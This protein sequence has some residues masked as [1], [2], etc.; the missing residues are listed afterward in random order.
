MT[1]ANLKITFL[2]FGERIYDV[3]K[4]NN[5]EFNVNEIKIET[6]IE[7][8]DFEIEIGR[9]ICSYEL[10]NKENEMEPEN[11]MIEIILGQ[12][13]AYCFIDNSGITFEF[14][15]LNKNG[16]IEQLIPKQ[17]DIF[18]KPTKKQIKVYPNKMGTIDRANLIL[19]N[20]SFNEIIAINNKEKIKIAD[21]TNKIFEFS[22]S[23]SYQ[24][25][26]S[27]NSFKDYS[28][29]VIEPLKELN[30]KSIF[31][32]YN[33]IA[34]AKYK[35]LID[36]IE[37]N[38]L[39]NLDEELKKLYEAY[40]LENITRKKYSY[41]NN[42]LKN[43]LNKIEYLNFIYKITLLNLVNNYVNNANS[44]SEQAKI[45]D[46]KKIHEYLKNIKARIEKDF[47]LELYEKILL[48]IE[49]NT[50]ENNILKD[51]DIYYFNIKS[52]DNDSPLKYAFNFLNDFIDDLN[53]NSEFYYPLLCID[54]DMFYFN[55]SNDKDKKYKISIYGFN[56][57]SLED[58]K[59]HLRGL[60][61]NLILYNINKKEN[62]DESLINSYS[63]LVTLFIS[64]YKGIEIHKKINDINER[65]N[66]AFQISR[67][68]MHQ[69]FGHKKSLLAKEGV[70]S[71]SPITFKNKLGEIKF[72][73][74]ENNDNQY[75]D[76]EDVF[77]DLAISACKGDSGYFFEYHLGY[78]N[79]CDTT[80]IIDYLK[81]KTNLGALLDTELWNS[82]IDILKEYIY[83]K[84]LSLQNQIK[85][86]E[87]LTIDEQL[88]YLKEKIKQQLETKE[89]DKKINQ[90]EKNSKID[91]N[92]KPK[93][94]KSSSLMIYNNFEFGKINIKR[95][96]AP[97]KK[98][99]IKY[100]FFSNVYRK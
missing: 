80:L 22:E 94:K 89:E 88:K 4:I 51:K 71:M 33:E 43:E 95:T 93:G 17:F 66:I 100:S 78:I 53:Y 83:Y 28:Y 62:N 9:K 20:C 47:N 60:I 26:F 11:G 68:L 82:K 57:L 87:N 18:R 58:I 3:F 81:D 41:T 19:I 97:K 91:S 44:D 70:L 73:T 72:I 38:N 85:I 59:K 79:G 50:S 35:N 6:N 15:F 61:P 49:L 23:K 52:I 40:T 54:S 96:P 32:K 21:I 8:T 27:D 64:E 13:T 65:K 84:Y 34:D 67:C 30:F 16:P 31:N 25:C 69:F 5:I 42:I 90:K 7:F 75:K 63:G 2:S 45:D 56:M 36:L 39:I 1:N 86:N 92:D 48:L 14:L 12:N 55:Y 98:K 37:N 46:I 76:L 74:E 29:R 24:I 99:K 10:I 77:D